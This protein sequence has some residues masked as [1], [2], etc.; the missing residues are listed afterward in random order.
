[1]PVVVM[2]V[3]GKQFDVSVAEGDTFSSRTFG[4]QGRGK[5][6]KAVS[7]VIYNARDWH[8]RNRAERP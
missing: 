2:S 3:A 8:F 1:M 7:H 4:A 5:R 6:H